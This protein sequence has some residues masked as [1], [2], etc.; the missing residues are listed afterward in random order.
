M[1]KPAPGGFPQLPSLAAE[2]LPG[3][4]PP[5]LAPLRCFMGARTDRVRTARLRDGFARIGLRCEIDPSQDAPYRVD[6]SLTRLPGLQMAA[7]RLYGAHSRRTRALPGAEADDTA[8]IVNLKGRHLIEQRGKEVELGDG[9]AVLVPWTEPSRLTHLPPGEALALRFPR[10]RLA[11][12]LRGR[13]ARD[14]Q[15]IPGGNPAME[16]LTRYVALGWDDRMQAAHELQRLMVSHIYDLLAVVIGATPDAAQMAQAGGLRAARLNAIKQD[17]EG[18]LDEPGLSVAAIA[19]RHGC[20]L[21]GVQ[22]LFEAEGTTFTAY[23]VSRRLARAHRLLTDP[24]HAAEKISTVAYACGFGDVSYFN[25]AFRRAYALS[26]SDVR[27][28][29]CRA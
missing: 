10:T 22:R 9:D 20:T 21:R 8:L 1:R 19:G 12:L 14:M 26:P 11:P 15:V 18:S 13:E 6:L 7:G 28:Q 24:R 29:A 4:A 25:R 23:V 27:A 16:L 3:S 5:P 2:T 17:I